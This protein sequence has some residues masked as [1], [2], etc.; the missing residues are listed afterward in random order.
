MSRI[1]KGQKKSVAPLAMMSNTKRKMGTAANSGAAHP[2]V[3][4]SAQVESTVTFSQTAVTTRNSA[5]SITQSFSEA[6]TQPMDTEGF[7]TKK[8]PAKLRP[9]DHTPGIETNNRF[10]KL[11]SA[12]SETAIATGQKSSQVKKDK[13]LALF[14]YEIDNKYTTI[15][16]VRCQLLALL[17]H[18]SNMKRISFVSK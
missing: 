6:D 15:S 10:H 11:D 13:P 2:P 18:T 14:I 9:S 12:A 1:H 17:S 4:K 3:K 5:H 16:H 8:N 7:I